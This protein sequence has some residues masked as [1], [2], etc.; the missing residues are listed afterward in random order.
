VWRDRTE[1]LIDIAHCGV[2]VTPKQ[3]DAVEQCWSCIVDLQDLLDGV[4][5]DKWG[6]TEA[7]LQVVFEIFG[8]RVDEVLR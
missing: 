6:R 4:L 7:W 5:Q 1:E 2:K 3:E 8:R